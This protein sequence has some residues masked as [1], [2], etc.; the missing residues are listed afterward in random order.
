VTASRRAAD[1]SYQRAGD[2]LSGYLA[3]PEG[4]GPHP[5]LLLVPDVRGLYEHYRE[6]A[7]RFASEGFATLAVDLYSREGE[8]DLP[9]MEAIFRWMAS[10]PDR[11]VLADLQSARDYLAARSDVRA[12][13]IGLAGFCMG[14]QYTLMGACT[15]DGLAAAVSFYGM[16]SYAATNDRKPEQ[17]IDMVSRL[18]CPYLAFFGEDDPIIPTIDVEALRA[19]TAHARHPVEIVTYRDAGHAFFNDARPEMYREAAARDAWPRTITF[20]KR[21]LEGG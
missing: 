11:R 14:G 3:L 19:R 5:A 4:K 16:L 17:P 2:P 8:P 20:L 10:L 15:L 6:V 21:H 13:A 12:N 7:Q 9:D 1:V 18:G